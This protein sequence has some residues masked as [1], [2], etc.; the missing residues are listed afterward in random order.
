MEM[1]HM[2]AVKAMT[3]MYGD[4]LNITKRI[5]KYGLVFIIA[6]YTAAVVTYLLAGIKF[7]YYTAMVYAKS[8]V[9]S[10]CKC[11]AALG[12]AVVMFEAAANR[13]TLKL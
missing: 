10:A 5:I 8:L 3:Q 1:I 7:D 9:D 4:F 2:K 6:V 11:V 13:T 12:F